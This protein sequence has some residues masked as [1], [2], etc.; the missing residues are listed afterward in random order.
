MGYNT[1][2]VVMNDYLSNIKDDSEFGK[3][4][5]DKVIAAAREKPL[6]VSAGGAVNAATVIESHHSSHYVPILVGGNHGK[7][8][9][10]IYIGWDVEDPELELLKRLAE[11][12]GYNLHRKPKKDK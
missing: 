4:L 12:H 9:E 1:T 7:V 3:K 2:I 10:G 8:M 11:K 6:D 5:A